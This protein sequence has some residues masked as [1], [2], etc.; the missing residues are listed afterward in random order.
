MFEFIA[1]MGKLLLAIYGLRLAIRIYVQRQQPTWSGPLARRRLTVLLILVLAVFAIK[2]VEDV[3]AGESGIFDRMILLFVHEHVP[4]KL[5]GFFEWVT[6]TGSSTFLS[7]LTAGTAITMLFARRRFEAFLLTA[8]VLCAAAV[9]YIVKIAVSRVRPTLWETDWYWGSSFPSGHTLVV[10]AFATSIA[11]SV[12]R[13]WPQARPLAV[14][15]AVSWISLVG[16]SRLVLGVHWPTD[17]LVAGC[18]GAILPL[19]V[20]VALDLHDA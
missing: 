8:S 18:I 9:V 14:T 4:R 1:D 16:L 13:A 20:S 11:L 17:V 7:V 5:T 15:V 2:M 6:F 10:A 19:V 12:T 3:L